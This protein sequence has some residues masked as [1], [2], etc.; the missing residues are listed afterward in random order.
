MILY[1]YKCQHCDNLFDELRD[2]E[3]RQWCECPNCN[4]TAYKTLGAATADINFRPRWFNNIAP[5]PVFIN[6]REE[7]TKVSNMLGNYSNIPF[8]KRESREIKNPTK[9][10]K[11]RIIAKLKRGQY[12]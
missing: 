10:E 6:S 4:N 5:V 1:Q 9:R 7:F 8:A 3:M 12:E 2:V 11:A